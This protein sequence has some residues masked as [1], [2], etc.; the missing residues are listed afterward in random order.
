MTDL[1]DFAVERLASLS[2]AGS[3]LARLPPVPQGARTPALLAQHDGETLWYD[4]VRLGPERV[5]LVCPK[6]GALQALMT[7]ASLSSSGSRV[8]IA[9]IRRHRRHDIVDLTGVRGD[10][11]T[12]T[13]GR[14][15]AESGLSPT[16]HAAFR[17]LNASV[18]ISRN[19]RLTWIADWARYHVSAHGLQA[20]LLLDNGS[21]DYP[22]E[23]ILDALRPTGLA[24]AV[25]LVVPQPYGPPRSKAHHSGAAKYLQ[26]AMLN[27]ARLR[28]LA[29]ARAVL[30]ADLDELIWTTGPTVFD[31]AA[32]SALGYVSFRGTW[33]LPRP[34]AADPR[35]ADHT[36]PRADAKPCP[37]KYCL[38]PNGPI[39]RLPW[40]VHR[41]D[42]TLLLSR[43]TRRDLGYWHCQA[44]T[45][46]WKAHDRLRPRDTAPEDPA[47]AAALARHLPPQPDSPLSAG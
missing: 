41:P 1:P 6:L 34:D 5:R 47:T 14:W 9:R 39:G 2:A 42:W 3:G 7:D 24:R 28:Y 31:A 16:R 36:F 4:A 30:N 38:T 32:D 40:D 37:T 8:R 11:L 21:T 25:V 18:Q 44:I 17:G 23:A 45:T 20:M 46:N 27:L 13:H 26:P 43:R 10:R 29:Q 22:P 33:R 35:H 15:Q 19:N 12:V